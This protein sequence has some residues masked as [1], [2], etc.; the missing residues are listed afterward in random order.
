MNTHS[1]SRHVLALVAAGALAALPGCVRFPVQL[2]DATSHLEGQ[3]SFESLGPAEG[4]ACQFNLFYLIPFGG[5][6]LWKAKERAIGDAD[7]LTDVSVDSSIGLAIIGTVACTEVR[8][9]RYKLVSTAETWQDPP[10]IPQA[11]PPDELVPLDEP[12]PEPEPELEAEPEPELEA[13]P[14][15]EPGDAEEAEAASEEPEP[16]AEEP[17]TVSE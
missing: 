14:Q 5:N 15:A 6:Q 12:E 10:V 4:K 13:E 16:T 3:R 1:F 11:P 9:T 8:G 7:G 17:T 2:Q